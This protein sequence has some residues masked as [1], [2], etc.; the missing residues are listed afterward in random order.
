MAERRYCVVGGDSFF[1]DEPFACYGGED[2]PVFSRRCACGR[3]LAMSKELHYVTD[4]AGC[5][6]HVTERATCARCGP[7]DMVL[8]GWGADFAW[9]SR[10]R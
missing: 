1:G 3:F 10:P 5:L 4:A 9:L 7:V 2:G 6:T 8:I